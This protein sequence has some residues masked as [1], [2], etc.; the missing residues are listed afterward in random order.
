MSKRA[1]IFWTSYAD[2]MTSLF[3]IMLVLFVLTISWMKKE[4]KATKDQLNKIKQ[5]EKTVENINREYFKYEEEY[6]RY[7]LMIDV[8]FSSNSSNIRDIPVSLR[9]DLLNAGKK[10]YEK[11]MELEKVKEVD[12]LLIIEGNAQKY[13]SNYIK[14]P[15][16]G[17][18]LSYNRSLSLVNFWK[19]N[20]ID[21]SEF[22]NCEMLIV[23]SGYF[24]KNRESNEV[25]NRKFTI[26]ITPKIRLEDLNNTKKN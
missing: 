3:F 25:E 14:A 2:L 7:K 19:Q 9:A 22:D 12:F 16:V 13:N 11:M 18:N 21:F 20:G 4:Q 6:K 15:D 10:L 26:Q 1:K 5:I 23:G 17:Y 24:G 8:N